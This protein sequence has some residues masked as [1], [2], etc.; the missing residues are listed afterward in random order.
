MRNEGAEAPSFSS[1]DVTQTCL[2]YRT[3]SL[4][5]VGWERYRLVDCGFRLGVGRRLLRFGRHC[6]RFENFYLFDPQTIERGDTE[7][8]PIGPDLIAD[9]R[10]P[11]QLAKHKTPK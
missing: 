4:P 9:F 3:N 2:A 11:A 5:A 10:F 1:L 7:E 8:M 6:G